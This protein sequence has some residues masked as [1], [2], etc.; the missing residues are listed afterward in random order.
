MG[1]DFSAQGPPIRSWAIASP[2]LRRNQ[3]FHWAED[4]NT[5]LPKAHRVDEGWRHPPLL[6]S[7]G[8]GSA[9][10][11]VAPSRA[12]VR[13]QKCM[14]P[15]VG[16]GENFFFWKKLRLDA[17]EESLKTRPCR[18]PLRPYGYGSVAICP[19]QCPIKPTVAIATPLFVWF[20]K[21]FPPALGPFTSVLAS[22]WV[23]PA[24]LTESGTVDTIGARITPGVQ[25][26]CEIS[27]TIHM[28]SRCARRISLNR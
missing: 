16:S 11:S 15:R 2:D 13:T 5:L 23:A 4:N 1:R 14:S 18:P 3:I 20:Y 9:L 22:V 7:D 21:S 12:G 26:G 8:H 24:P 17:G 19:D 27:R 25:G 6:L 28:C 10:R